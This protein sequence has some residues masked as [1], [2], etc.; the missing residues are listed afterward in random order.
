MTLT[1]KMDGIPQVFRRVSG[2]LCGSANVCLC[3][4]ST[5]YC[6]LA[7]VR[8]AGDGD[9]AWHALGLVLSH[10]L[11]L[12]IARVLRFLECAKSVPVGKRSS[13]RPVVFTMCSG[14]EWVVFLEY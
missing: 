9:G 1:T 12:P 11:P 6:L 5:L 3:I 13:S 4:G 8:T 10:L 14:L 7:R 2:K